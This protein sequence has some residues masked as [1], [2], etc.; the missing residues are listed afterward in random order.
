MSAE[1]LRGHVQSQVAKYSFIP[2][3]SAF[4]KFF[5]SMAGGGGGLAPRLR[6]EQIV[7]CFDRPRGGP[8][9]TLRKTSVLFDM[10][11]S[12]LEYI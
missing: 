12:S 10:T 9:Y 7:T 1:S 4:L 2:S 11:R 8:A 5:L 6:F 3:K